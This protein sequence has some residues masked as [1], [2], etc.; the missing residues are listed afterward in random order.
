MGISKYLEEQLEKS[1]VMKEA[2]S[3][4]TLKSVVIFAIVAIVGYI[5]ISSASPEAAPTAVL[6]SGIFAILGLI[7]FIRYLKLHKPI[8][9]NVYEMCVQEIKKNLKADESIESFDEDILKPAFGVHDYLGGTAAVGKKFV[10]FNRLNLTGPKFQILRADVLG[11]LKV[12]YS[13]NAGVSQDIGIDLK[14]KDGNFIRSVLFQDKDSLYK[15]LDALEKFKNYNNRDAS[16]IVDAEEGQEDSLV[17]ET[18]SKISNI[19]RSSK[20]KLTVVGLVF[21]AFLTIAGSG[22]GVAFIY[23]GIFLIT[24]SLVSLIYINICKRNQPKEL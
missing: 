12:Y 8:S 9:E 4:K 6:F 11:D 1:N 2:Q 10:L 20:T 13:A 15:L 17:Y 19:D 24:I 23:G 5:G 3:K 18:K 14:A 21:G 7:F 22:S 16:S